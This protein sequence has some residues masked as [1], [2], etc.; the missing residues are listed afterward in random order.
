MSSITLRIS[1][2]YDEIKNVNKSC[3]ITINT[4]QTVEELED[5]VL[6]ALLFPNDPKFFR[7]KEWFDCSTR[8]KIVFEGAE[9]ISDLRIKNNS[10][11]MVSIVR[12]RESRKCVP[13]TTEGVRLCL[14]ADKRD[15]AEEKKAQ[16]QA[17]Q[18]VANGNASKKLKAAGMPGDGIRLGDGE[19]IMASKKKRSV[20][21]SHPE[22]ADDATDLEDKFLGSV[23]AAYAI[24]L[25]DGDIGDLTKGH[26]RRKMQDTLDEHIL[27]GTVQMELDCIKAGHYI[28]KQVEDVNVL[29]GNGGEL[30]MKLFQVICKPVGEAKILSTK[31]SAELHYFLDV[32]GTKGRQ[33]VESAF[34]RASETGEWNLFHPNKWMVDAPQLIWGMVLKCNMKKGISDSHPWGKFHSWTYIN[35]LQTFAPSLDWSELRDSS[36]V[37][38][39][40]LRQRKGVVHYNA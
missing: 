24:D 40:R 5:D 30:D 20:Q 37:G 4:E 13:N 14:A 7:V 28:I 38:E 19:V 34:K 26:W 17:A 23:R 18:K 21:K 11:L 1:T 33:L 16:K 2:G 3:F 6:S 12:G 25:N 39:Q 31:R 8:S 35:L 10:A 29:G 27:L 32:N 36:I 15:K 22:A 9:K